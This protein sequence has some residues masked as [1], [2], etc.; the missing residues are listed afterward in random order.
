MGDSSDGCHCNILAAILDPFHDVRKYYTSGML[1]NMTNATI[2]HKK[3]LFLRLG[4]FVSYIGSPIISS[5]ARVD[6]AY[7]I[8]VMLMTLRCHDRKGCVD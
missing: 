3:K 2:I 8:T 1:I 4:G 6:T 7:S 5:C